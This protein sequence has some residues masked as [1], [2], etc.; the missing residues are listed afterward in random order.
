MLDI[1]FLG[2]LLIIINFYTKNGA[3]FKLSFLPPAFNNTGSLWLVGIFAALF[4]LKNWFGFA[5]SKFQHHFF[6]EVASRLS[7]RNMMYY[8]RSEYDRFV[9]TDS[10]VFVRNISQQPIEFSAYIL[11]NFQQVVSQTILIFFTICAI[12]FYHPALFFLLFLLLA[13]PVA[14]LGWFIRKKLKSVRREIKT[15]GEKTLQHAHESLGGYI[16]SNVY[17][18]SEFFTG[19]FYHYQ[20]Q[21]D[22][23]IAT[24]QSLQSLPARLVEVFA[25]AGFF[26]L[27]A[28][29][30][31]SLGTPAVNL[32]T[33]GVFMAAAYKIIPG[34]IK[35]LNCAGQIK[36]YHFVVND[37]DISADATETKENTPIDKIRSIAVHDMF[38]KYGRREVLTDL[39]F[40]LLPGDFTGISAPSGSGKTTIVNLLL[41]FLT[42]DHGTIMINNEPC[43]IVQLKAWRNRMSYVKQQSFFIHDT[44]EKNITLSDDP[45]DAE[46][47]ERVS[48]ICGLDDFLKKY[49]EG[50]Q[51]VI[52][53]NGKNISGGERQRIMLARALYHESD[54]LILDEPFSELDECSEK[55]ILSQLKTLAT[56]GKIILLITHNQD[57]LL[58]CTQVLALHGVPA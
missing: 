42:P 8:F 12:L 27:I 40:A 18:K 6:Y 55:A 51:K 24:Q 49:P 30:K 16:E 34:I 9:H 28:I 38:F 26:I 11:T 48:L 10:S 2:L 53:E 31:L 37:L 35:I 46:K 57:S 29:N 44:V 58:F 15:V 36:T 21:L 17:N 43:D 22:E 54:V 5:L 33:I 13:P 47:L 32:L 23:N 56:G 19:R 41:G 20:H 1:A 7:R 52:T 39:N 25:V 3:S 4:S 50:W 14:A 45:A